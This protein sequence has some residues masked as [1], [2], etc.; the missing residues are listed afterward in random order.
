LFN[1]GNFIWSIGA[2]ITQTIFDGGRIHAQNDLARAEEQ[3]LIASYRKAVFTAFQDVETALGTV[4]ST[5]DQLA[6]IE[7]ETKADAE[8]F[9]ISELQ[10]REGTIDIVS[11]LNNQQNL[12]AAQQS[13]VQTRL[14]KLEAYIALYNALGGGWEQKADDAAYKNQLDWWPL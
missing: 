12:F 3:Q 9:R 8:A 1:S 5:D 11:L 14:A 13:L 4:K 10:Y 2:G 7:V 6:L